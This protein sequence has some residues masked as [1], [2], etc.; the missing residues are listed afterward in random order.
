[1][2]KDNSLIALLIIPVVAI[3]IYSNTFHSSFHFDDLIMIVKNRIVQNLWNLWPPSGTRYI[4]LLSF[5]LNYQLG[6]LNVLGYHMVNL[7]I[8]IAN[9]LMVLWLVLLTFK[10]PIMKGRGQTLQQMNFIA[11]FSA[12]IFI[13][14]P[15]QTQA[16]TY[17]VQRFTS[18]ATLFYLLALVMY[19]KARL[20]VESPMVQGPKVEKMQRP[21]ASRF[22]PYYLLSIISTLL[23]MKTKEISFTL[24]FVMILYEFSF[25]NTTPS[26]PTFTKMKRLSFLIPFLMALLIIPLSLINIEKPLGDIIGE[27]RETTQETHEIPRISYLLTQSRVIMTYLRL[28]VLPLN[29]NLDYDYPIYHSITLMVLLSSLFIVLLL[30]LAA[31][32]FY[33]SRSGDRRLRL[34]AFGIFWFFITLSVESSIIPIKD[35]IV[36]HRLYLPS[37]GMVIALSSILWVASTRIRARYSPLFYNSLV[38]IAVVIPLGVGTYYRNFTWADEVTLWEDVVKKSPNKARAHLNL[39]LIYYGLGQ[40]DQAIQRYTTAVTLQPD[41][42]WAHNNLG[43]TYA[44]QGRLDEAMKELNIAL[45]LEPNLAEAHNNL[46][47]IYYRQQRLDEA[48]KEV[49]LALNLKP[50]FPEAHNNLGNIYLQQKRL[51]LAAQEY[52]AALSLNPGYAE[53]HNNLGTVYANQGRLDEAMKEVT[54]ALNLKANFPEAHNN[55]GNIFYRQRRLDEAVREYMAAVR[56][57]PDSVIAHYNLANAFKLKG[58]TSE[59]R[60]QYEIALAL[61]PNF[62]PAQQAIESLEAS[63]QPSSTLPSR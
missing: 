40:L 32:L 22:L 34:I 11:L 63:L 38:F 29:Q 55:L 61:Q 1:M 37:V 59:A 33:K 16:V 8:H 35:I 51:D 27:L 49:S 30:S 46:G 3:L 13:S 39:G 50:D 4:G 24:P 18:L 7:A 14:H 43:T 21:L 10:T 25:F 5:A 62:T 42:A 36:E 41:Y 19:V 2:K 9:G 58:L 6:G 60:R 31:Y 48:M 20:L 47:N 23:A 56:L 53:A 17:I 52:I 26:S 44:T 45:S 12:L 57:S 54:L 15:I 28:L